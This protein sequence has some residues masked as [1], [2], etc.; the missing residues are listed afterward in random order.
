MTDYITANNAA[1]SLVV[2]ID[3]NATTITVVDGSKFP[4]PNDTQHVVCTLGGV[5]NEIVWATNIAG[6]V[7]TILRAQEGTTAVAWPVGTLIANKWTSEQAQTANA[8]TKAAAVAAGISETNAAGSATTATTQA[9]IAT[10]QVGLAAAQVDLATAQVGLAT[11]QAGLAAASATTATNAAIAISNIVQVNDWWPGTPKT[12]IIL[13]SAS[14]GEIWNSATEKARV[15]ALELAGTQMRLA[16]WWPG[17]PASASPWYLDSNGGVIIPPANS[18]GNVNASG[19]ASTQSPAFTE[20][21][22]FAVPNNLAR[23]VSYFNWRG[24]SLAVYGGNYTP[25]LY[26]IVAIAPGIVL[27]PVTGRRPNGST[28][29]IMIDAV[30]QYY[31]AAGDSLG[32]DPTGAVLSVPVIFQNLVYEIISTNVSI[33]APN[34][35]LV[36]GAGGT[37][38]S[39][40]GPGS[41]TGQQS[42]LNMQYA[43]DWALANGFTI[44]MPATIWIHGNEDLT[45][46][47][48]AQYKNWLITLQRWDTVNARSIFGQTEEVIYFVEQCTP[49]STFFGQYFEVVQAQLDVPTQFP[50][51]FA[52]LPPCYNYPHGDG[53]HLIAPAY[54]CRDARIAYRVTD[55]LYA[56]GRAPFAFTNSWWISATVLRCRI[57]APNAPIVRDITFNSSVVTIGSTGIITWPNNPIQNGTIIYLE[58]TGSLLTGY[59]TQTQYY[60]VNASGNTFQLS[61]TFQ[62]APIIASGSQSGTHTAIAGG[63][64]IQLDDGNVLPQ[65]AVTISIASPAVVTQTAHGYS[66]GQIRYLATTNL[67]PTGLAAGIP[68][69][70]VNPTTDTYQ[71]APTLGGSAIITSGSQS[72]T[73][74]AFTASPYLKNMVITNDGVSSGQ[75][76]P[77][78]KATVD[79]TF[80]VAP[81]KYGLKTLLIAQLQAP[82]ATAQ[83][84]PG[85]AMCT[86][87]N[88]SIGTSTVAPNGTV[89]TFNLYDFVARG[90]LSVPPQ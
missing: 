80:N 18:F 53:T 45:L 13:L 60:S 49:A 9:G 16:D 82:G 90:V 62:G 46:M 87:R 55:F 14:L 67:L 37:S 8:E 79:L 81:A 32:N 1:S 51:Q 75:S 28:F 83:G 65:V 66:S 4:V 50:L 19:L 5:V 54:H 35:S 11:T 88:S 6:N 17:Y 3:G 38:I 74:T 31:T 25:T 36:S 33:Q 42:I 56:G 44:Y 70:V 59:A 77:N 89:T 43:R 76:D 86:L 15:D 61:P 2:A 21:F 12:A 34:L 39:N 7:F 26:D 41:I 40:L 20:V 73:Q 71:L 58:T 10:A 68:Y 47:S 48:A 78:G 69:Y 64:G 72:G 57:E 27:M 30:D 85:S 24:Q 63:E 52:F 29:N 84:S 22:S 23:R